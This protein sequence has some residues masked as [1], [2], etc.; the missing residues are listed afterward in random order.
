MFKTV[1]STWP[2]HSDYFNIFLALLEILPAFLTP[3]VAVEAAGV[4]PGHAL[5]F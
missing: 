5:A 1:R 3:L 4:F 2:T